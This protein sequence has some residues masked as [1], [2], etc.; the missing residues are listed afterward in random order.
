[1]LEPIGLM[2]EKFVELRLG[3]RTLDGW[4]NVREGQTW[5]STMIFVMVGS[6]MGADG[7]SSE[8]SADRADWNGT[9]GPKQNFQ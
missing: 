9:S 7:G 2:L 4:M 3:E 5:V 1:M 6:G 8:S